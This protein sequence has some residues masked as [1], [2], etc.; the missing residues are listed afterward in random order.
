MTSYRTNRS[1][2][3]NSAPLKALLA[4]TAVVLLLFGSTPA[5]AADVTATWAKRID[6]APEGVTGPVPVV[7]FLHGCSGYGPGSGAMFPDTRAWAETITGA[8]YRFVVPDSWARSAWSRP[9]LCP[10]GINSGR[11]GSNPYQP[12]LDDVLKVRL[13]RIEEMAYAVARLKEDPTVDQNRIVIFGHSEGGAVVATAVPPPSV[14]GLII[15]G[16]ACHGK[17]PPGTDVKGLG[18]AAPPSIPLLALE[19]EEDNYY[20]KDRQGRCSEFFPGRTDAHEFIAP[21]SGHIIGGI[22]AAR[23]AVINFLGDLK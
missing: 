2:L 20:T 15:S 1:Y 19:F 10:N 14:R 9:N 21:G 12:P 16:W 23:E 3:S 8:G 22:A 7:V 17:N 18:I 6:K 4:L 13:M 11:S 5:S